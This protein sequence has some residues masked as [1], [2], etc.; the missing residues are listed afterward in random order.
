LL[1][2]GITERVGPTWRPAQLKESSLKNSYLSL[3]D[4]DS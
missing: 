2:V 3:T 1:H 4:N